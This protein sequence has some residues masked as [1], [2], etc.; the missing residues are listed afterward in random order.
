[1]QKTKS[2]K[3]TKINTKI[4]HHPVLLTHV[5]SV[6]SPKL[7]ESYLDLTA[8]YGGHAKA[9]LQQTQAPKK[10]VLVDRDSFAIQHLSEQFSAGEQVRQNDYESTS[11]ELLQSNAQFDLILA[12]IGV[13]S[14]HLDN[15]SRGFSVKL[16]GPLD[17]RMDTTK[18][19]TAADIVNTYDEQELVR[20]IKE[21]GEEPKARHIV[22]SIIGH[23]PFTTTHQ[24]ANVVASAWRGRRSKHHPAIRTFQALRIAVND[25]L[26]QLERA[27]P[28]WVKL[29]KP[30]GR[31]AVI[32]FH[33][34]E[35]RIVKRMLA[36][37]A[38]DRYDATL[39]LL[40][41]Q[42]IT[43]DDNELVFNPRARSAKLRAAVKIKN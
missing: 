12:D 7:G 38:G 41:K 19:V 43:A 29:L 25:E 42:P 15:A 39:R 26:G 22:R 24:L 20:I 10:A 3:N 9:V 17:M 18:G 33:S 40:T 1:M 27:I 23:R 4:K 28:L 14:P 16:D 30:E 37:Y 8:G 35:D 21:Y 6:L 31:L 2:M 11:E 34:L 32:S 5:L 13:S 36:S